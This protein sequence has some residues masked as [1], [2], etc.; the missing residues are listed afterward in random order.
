MQDPQVIMGF[1]T[2]SW[3]TDLDDFV[4][5]PWF[6]HLHIYFYHVYMII[7]INVIT[8]YGSNHTYLHVL[9]NYKIAYTYTHHLFVMFQSCFTIMFFTYKNF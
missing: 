2:K 6:G 4:V 5:P 1:N 9:I 8:I 7:Y 3:S